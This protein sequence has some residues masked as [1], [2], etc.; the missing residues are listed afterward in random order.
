FKASYLVFM[1]FD[2]DEVLDLVSGVLN[3]RSEV[4]QIPL[5]FYKGVLREGKLYFEEVEKAFQLAPGP[6]SSLSVL[7]YDLDGYPD[8]FMG[9]WLESRGGEYLPVAD[10][11][12]RFVNDK[13][14]D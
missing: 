6:T 10:R 5:K 7:D 3:Q 4:S 11:L 8:L 14:V 2:K 9:N 12:L 1:D 13:F